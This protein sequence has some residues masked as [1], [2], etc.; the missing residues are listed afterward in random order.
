MTLGDIDFPTPREGDDCRI[1]REILDLVGDK[2]TLYIIVT[3][4]DGPVRFNELRRKIDG[5][6]QRM[7]TINLRGLERNGLVKRTL[8]PTIPPRV[9]YELTSVGR[10]L[11]AP[12]MALVTW[13]NTNQE[14]IQDARVRYDAS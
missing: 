9:D 14:N 10:T 11:L 1:V 6:S 13:A 8:F 5:I 2:W 7:L 12:V 3:L 4:K